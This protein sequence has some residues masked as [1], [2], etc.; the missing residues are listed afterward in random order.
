MLFVVFINILILILINFNM[1]IVFLR[2]LRIYINNIK[3]FGGS[4]VDLEMARKLLFE[5]VK[6]QE[7]EEIDLS[8]ALG[9]VLANDIISPISSPPFD[10]SPLDGYAV[11]ACDL[12]KASSN[13]PVELNIIGKTFAGES[14]E[15]KVSENEA[16]RIMT[17]AMIPEG[18]DCVVR[19][20]NTEVVNPNKV[21]IFISH[22]VHENYI[23]K[24]E[25]FKESTK[26]IEKNIR[27]RA[28]EVMA[29][30]SLGME[31]IKVYKK[32]IVGVITVGDEIQNPGEVLKRGKIFNAN[33]AFLNA[34]ITEL[35]G[36]SKFYEV[37]DSGDDI[38]KTI[39]QAWRE[40][41]LI[42]STGGVSVGE[43]DFVRQ[44]AINAGFKI[45]FW[46]IFMKPG[47]PMFGGVLE[48]RIYL[49]LSGTPVACATTFELTVRGVIA[50]M[51]SCKDIDI[52]KFYC[53]IQNDTKKCSKKRRFL[54]ARVEEDLK[55]KVFINS[56]YQSPGQISTMIK[57]NAILEIKAGVTLHKGDVV[58]IIR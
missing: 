8:D 31:K 38:T 44:S 40:C 4:M 13:H 42:V 27:L 49:G 23:F 5:R 52:K 43:K 50:R 51:L 3:I 57:S 19:Q 36:L 16:V 12:S 30:A 46:K 32:P 58:E 55:S 14:T 1:Q 9:R 26:I 34:R 53:V 20:E 22:C 29:I 48:D 6:K 47:S 17:G 35:G 21:K 24:G 18:A 33:K 54:R 25:D 11:R 10:K 15:Y 45:L 28:S 41:D 56:V 39:Q 2:F 7:I 37:I